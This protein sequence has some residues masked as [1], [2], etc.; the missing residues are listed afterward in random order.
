MS[1]ETAADVSG[2]FAAQNDMIGREV[3]GRFRIL[4]K[5]GEGGMGAVY[6]GEQIALKRAVAIKV[7]RNELSANQM[8]LSRFRAEAEA[9]ARLDHPNTV[10]VYDTGQ[11]TDG[12]LFIAMEYIDGK[13]L[14]QII[15]QGPLRPV[16]AFHIALQIAAS[17]IDEIGRASCRER[18]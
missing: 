14:R 12:A 17:L 18:V 15:A 9:I 7:L 6:R 4:A 13:S 3:V 8:V 11:D 16:R 5:L 1:T 10:R 2:P